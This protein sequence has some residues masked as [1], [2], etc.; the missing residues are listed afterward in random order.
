MAKRGASAAVQAEVVKTKQ[1]TFYLVKALFDGGETVCVTDT[2]RS[3][4]F[5]GDTY[6]A[7]GE[8]LAVSDI[9]ESVELRVS[10]VDIAF[11]ISDPNREI[12]AAMLTH[13]Y[14]G[15]PVSI[16]RAWWNDSFELISNPV[17]IFSGRIDEPAVRQE[18]ADDESGE[19]RTLM[20]VQVV[21][22]LADFEMQAGRVTNNASQQ[23]FFPG[24][25]FLEFAADIVRE[26]RWGW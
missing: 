5:N 21:N 11:G 25:R 19:S 14:V 12:L 3:V 1:R 18:I 6:L 15:R 7:L 26:Y 2:F 16:W 24:D 22:D 23:L 8:L 9:V 10:S 20:S 17:M 13:S 4:T